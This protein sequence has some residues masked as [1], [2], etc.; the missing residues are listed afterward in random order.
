MQSVRHDV[1][2]LSIA[3][4][5]ALVFALAWGSPFVTVPSASAQEPVQPKPEQSQKR[6]STFT[7]TIARTG[8][9]YVLR[10]VSG[11]TYSLDDADL[12]K[13]FEGKI[14][15]ITG[16]LDLEARMIHVEK[17]ELMAA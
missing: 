16:L 17:I 8:E 5:F 1:V 6:S 14:V 13:K 12:A 3:S 9:Q 11:A 15:K 7:G 2:R 10:E 4:V